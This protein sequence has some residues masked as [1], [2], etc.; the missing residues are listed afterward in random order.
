MRRHHAGFGLPHV[1]IVFVVLG[2]LLAG[3]FKWQEMVSN[4]KVR[5]VTDQIAAIQTAVS[6][7][8]ARFHALPGD[9]SAATSNISGAGGNGDGDGVV[10][11]DVERGYFWQHLANAGFI[12]GSFDG[13]AVVGTD[14]ICAPSTC[15]PNAFGGAMKYS[16]SQYASGSTSN[17]H[18]L[19]IG[20]N[21][22]VNILAEIDRKI[23]DGVP[24]TGIFRVDT[25]VNL[26]SCKSGAGAT[27][28]YNVAG[29]QQ[30][31]AGVRIY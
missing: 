4:A 17:A 25:Q 2:L 27:S 9:Y 11:T 3:I 15:P 8:Q 26:A 19:R 24:D 1:A 6:A 12:L 21:I 29:G 16:W 7:F 14:L 22:P 5:S 20:R 31:C 28:T 30:D 13:A 10:A 23:D 18:E